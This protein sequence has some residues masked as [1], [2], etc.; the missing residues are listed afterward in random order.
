M[1]WRSSV[2]LVL[3]A[4]GTTVLLLTHRTDYTTLYPALLASAVGLWLARDVPLAYA[5]SVGA[6]LRVLAVTLPALLSDDY[7]RF[8]WDGRLWLAG[9]HPLAFVPRA[10]TP[11]FA[12]ANAELLAGMNSAG[13]FTVYPPVSQLAFALSAAF[14]KTTGAGLVL[15]KALLLVGEAAVGALL[16]RL[17]ASAGR[18]GLALYALCPLVVVEVCGNAHFESLAVLG[19][20]AAV[21]GFRQNRPWVSGVGLGFGVLTKLVPALAGPALLLAWGW[22]RE[23]NGGWRWASA[24]R[25]ALAAA[26]TTALGMFAFLS[27]VAWSGFGES[28]DLYFRSFEFNGS[29]YAVAAELG[30]W[31][32]GWNWIAVVGPGLSVVAVLGILAVSAWGAYRRWRLAETLLWCFAVW[33][34]CATTVHPWYAIYLVALGALTPYRWPWVLSFAVFVSYLAYGQDPVAVPGWALGVE[35]GVVVGVMVWEGVWR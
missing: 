15:L 9:Y 26:A 18:R 8:L 25:F 33:L 10:A 11:G 28:L 31:Y 27:P 16:Y 3:V 13:Y 34:A 4:A 6:A 21:W 29:L 20:L 1:T 5:L 22:R 23:G 30:A 2:G 35:Y 19:L 32:K 24:L 17:D 12:E 14:A 7:F